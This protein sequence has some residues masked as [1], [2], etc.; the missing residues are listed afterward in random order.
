MVEAGIHTACGVHCTEYS[1]VTL[2]ISSIHQSIKLECHYCL[3]Q[4]VWYSIDAFT[5]VAQS[6]IAR[7]CF[8][9]IH[10]AIAS[11]YWCESLSHWKFVNADTHKTR[12]DFRLNDYNC[13]KSI[14]WLVRAH[15]TV[16]IVRWYSTSRSKTP[17][18]RSCTEENRTEG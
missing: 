6:G 2:F 17:P 3:V 11:L 13:S 16:T 18:T 9:F 14:I 10:I 4:L 15:I 1:A 12:A 7:T 5:A 8:V